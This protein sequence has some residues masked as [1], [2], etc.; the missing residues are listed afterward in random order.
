MEEA[1]GQMAGSI[2]VVTSKDFSRAISSLTPAYT[3]SKEHLF[4]NF[5]PLGY[6]SCGEAHRQVIESVLDMMHV[7]I[8]SPVT[9]MQSLL[10][11]GPRGSGKTTLAVH[12]ATM[13][14][15]S[16]VKIVT[17]SLLARKHVSLKSDAIGEIFEDAYK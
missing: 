17:A 4:T 5:M 12:L 13:R 15:F 10:L 3:Q 8:T 9:P 16:F 6:L 1:N 11:Y 7:F 14:K 2:I